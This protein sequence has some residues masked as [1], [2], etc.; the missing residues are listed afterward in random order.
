MK[1]IVQF[2]SFKSPVDGG[3]KPPFLTHVE[4]IE[5][6]TQMDLDKYIEDQADLW[7]SHYKKVDKPEGNLLANEFSYSSDFGGVVVKDW[8]EMEFV[9][10]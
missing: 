2:Y 9:K 10:V 3:L 4:N 7:G 8:I 1:K 6:E 5:A